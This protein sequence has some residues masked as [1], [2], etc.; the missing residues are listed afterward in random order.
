MIGTA[1]GNTVGGVPVR[2]FLQKGDP[3]PPPSN[4]IRIYSMRFCPY[5]D[6][7]MIVAYKKGIPFE[8][9]YVNL[10]NKPEWFVSQ[11][12]DGTVPVLEHHGKL[13]ADSRVI[14]EYLDDVFSETSILSKE[15]FIRAK[16]RYRAN[17]LEMLCETIRDM[18]YSTK[19]KGNLTLLAMDLA[20]AEQML[21]STFFS[22]ELPSLPDIV[23][24]PFFQ[25]LHVMRQ[26]I[27][28]K[29]LDT[30]LPNNYPKLVNWF[31]RMREMP[32]IRVVHES[33]RYLREFLISKAN[34]NATNLGTDLDD[35]LLTGNFTTIL[36]SSDN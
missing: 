5:C 24:F 19:L 33:E 27:K 13:L 32:E 17:K 3:Q 12:A 18:S 26:F 16:Q 30:Y 34:P 31:I 22:G 7:V 35:Q 6:R 20:M 11:H 4:V 15:P 21:E 8:L 1:S 29:F 25:R 28:D 36:P 10:S 14:I 2:K 23:L 9:W